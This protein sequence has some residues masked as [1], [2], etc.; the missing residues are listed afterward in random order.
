MNLLGIDASSGTISLSVVETDKIIFDFNRH[1]T[2]GASRIVLY[3]EQYLK[4]KLFDLKNIDALVVGKGPGSFTGLRVSYSITKALSLSL[5]KPVI[6]IG[7][8]F[9]MAYNFKEKEENIAVITDARK[10]LV[11]AAAFRAERST[12]RMQ[13]KE[14]L[15]PLKE[16]IEARDDYF[17]VTHD[18]HIRT[19]ALTFKPHLRFHKE[20]VWPRAANMLKIAQQD[21]LKGM[22][23]PLEKLEP[24]YLHPKTCQ[25][26]SS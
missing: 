2:F 26:R 4:K 19:Q 1:L 17:F 25:I 8:F 12:L 6:P 3:L 23:T 13:G 18:E 20:C 15:L 14:Q 21:Y 9:S 24:L 10:N 16:F 5:N 22:F 7:S 11:Y